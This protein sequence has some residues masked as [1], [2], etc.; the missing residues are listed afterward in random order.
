[1]GR[2]VKPLMS[3]GAQQFAGG[4]LTLVAHFLAMMDV[5]AHIIER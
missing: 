5:E 4:E 3:G 1:M 2:E